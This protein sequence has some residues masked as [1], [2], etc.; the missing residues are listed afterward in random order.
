MS[1]AWFGKKRI[2]YGYRPNTLMGWLVVLVFVVVL[3]GA[4]FIFL[5]GNDQPN[6]IGFV[7]VLVL[8]LIAMF[9]VIRAKSETQP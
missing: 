1:T 4:A 9:L 7:V 6:Y 2:G 5:L 3:V 8:A